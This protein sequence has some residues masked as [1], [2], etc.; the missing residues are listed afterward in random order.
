MNLP[1]SAEVIIIGGGVMGASSAYH[2]ASRGVKD[3]LLLEKEAFCGQGATGRCAGGVRYQF[4]T[5]VNVCL[6]MVNLPMLKRFENETGIRLRSGKITGV[7]TNQGLVAT[8]ILVN[9]AGPWAGFR[10]E[11]RPGLGI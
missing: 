11:R 10:P 3:V 2:R 8:P 5:E 9:A 4:G 6:S 1:A 7:E